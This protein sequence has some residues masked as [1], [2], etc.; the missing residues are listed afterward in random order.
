[1]PKG[2]RLPLTWHLLT[3][4]GHWAVLARIL[5]HAELQNDSQRFRHF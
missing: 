2:I 5:V 3:E 4:L 1:L